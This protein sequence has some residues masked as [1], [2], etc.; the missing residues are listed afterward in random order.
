MNLK[1]NLSDEEFSLTFSY[2]FVAVSCLNKCH[3]IN[4]TI[5]L[6]LLCMRFPPL[7]QNVIHLTNKMRLILSYIVKSGFLLVQSL[8]VTVI[9]SVQSYLYFYYFLSLIYSFIVCT[10]YKYDFLVCHIHFQP[11][12][13]TMYVLIMIILAPAD[14]V[15]FRICVRSFQFLSIDFELRKYWLTSVKTN[16]I[17]KTSDSLFIT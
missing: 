12:E 11:T 6:Q 9:G 15:I 8:Y 16:E 3:R 1:F 17:K 4:G 2:I 10:I 13:L 5:S 14:I 7:W